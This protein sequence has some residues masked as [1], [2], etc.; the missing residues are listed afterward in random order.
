MAKEPVAGDRYYYAGGKKVELAP[1]DDLI[2]VDASALA[3][4]R[5]AKEIEATVRRNF[6]PLSGGVGLIHRA[7]LGSEANEVVK[8]LEEAGVTHPVFRSYGA[9][10]VVLPEVRVEE[11]RGGA[12]QKH[13][14]DW[15]ASHSK[16]ALVKS[17]AE[18]RVVL[19][20]TSGYG[21][22]A[23]ALANQLAEQVGPE[24]AQARFLRIVPRASTVRG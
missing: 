21:G 9:V 1:A 2:A 8:A 12:K 18:G 4:R 6:K 3:D 24:M 13:L 7:D 22:D 23:L 5:V 16:D 10:V 17:R 19:E 11:G 14:A 15:L 20:P